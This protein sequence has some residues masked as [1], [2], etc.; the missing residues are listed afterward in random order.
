MP[1]KAYPGKVL[2]EEMEQGEEMTSAGIFLKDDNGTSEGVR[3]RWAKV[4]AIG[5][6][7]EGI[8]VGN[9]ILIHH[10]RW[11]R[12]IDY[13]GKIVHLVDWPNAVQAYCNSETVPPWR[14]VGLRKEKEFSYSADQ[15]RDEARNGYF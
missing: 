11:T 10:G 13:D 6:G 4:Y 5:E 2:V 9:W 7:V 12:G 14:S 15:F 1:I 8:E 3:A